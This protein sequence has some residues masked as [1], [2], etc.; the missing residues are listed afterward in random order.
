M[1]RAVCRIALLTRVT[2]C[3]ELSPF[4]CTAVVEQADV[5]ERLGELEDVVV[6]VVIT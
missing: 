3:H 2:L 5:D 6:R 4:L 1:A